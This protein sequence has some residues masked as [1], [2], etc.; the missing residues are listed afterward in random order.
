[1]FGDATAYHNIKRSCMYIQDK[2]AFGLPM[3]PTRLG[4]KSHQMNQ[5]M[6]NFL[7]KMRLL[8]FI[9][10]ILNNSSE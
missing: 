9:N 5:H 7:L 3:K 6:K 1:M 8:N 2:K 4:E 10:V